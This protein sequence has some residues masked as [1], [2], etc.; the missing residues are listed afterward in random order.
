MKRTRRRR[1]R[2]T[3]CNTNAIPPQGAESK[4][5]QCPHSTSCLDRWSLPIQTLHCC[6]TLPSSVVTFRIYR[7]RPSRPKG[8]DQKPCVSLNVVLYSLALCQRDRCIDPQTFRQRRNRR[9]T[10]YS[11]RHAP[12]GAERTASSHSTYCH[13][14][15]LYQRDRCVDLVAVPVISSL[16]TIYSTSPSR[17]RGCHRAACVALNVLS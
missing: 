1:N 7:A 13:S 16:R 4:L 14:S 2:R 9:T 10:I 8:A 15:L 6:E 3:I 17:R 11:T 12:K 5:L